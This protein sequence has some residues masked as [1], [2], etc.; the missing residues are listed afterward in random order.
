MQPVATLAARRI[1]AS[2]QSTRVQKN[3]PFGNQHKKTKRKLEK[4]ERKVNVHPW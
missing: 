4:I 2:L 1:N 3:G